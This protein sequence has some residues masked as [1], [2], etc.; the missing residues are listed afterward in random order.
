MYTIAKIKY[1]SKNKDYQKQHPN[2]VFPSKYFL[3]ETY[4]LDYKD[5]KE[6]GLATAKEI[7]DWT[8][9]YLSAPLKIL[10]WGCGV[11][12]IIRHIPALVPSNALV[13]GTDI[14][15]TMIDWNKQ[16]IKQVQFSAIGYNPPTHFDDVQFNLVYAL[17]VFTHIQVQQQKDWLAEMHRILS[18]NGIF[19][20]TT[21]GKNFES[22]LSK[23][24]K[25]ILHT[26]GALTIDYS[27][28]G[29]R[30]MSSYNEYE[31]F[32]NTIEKQFTIIAYYD[33]LQHPNIIGGQDMWIVRKEK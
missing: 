31:S 25:L 1:G 28:K 5:Y 18:V 30:M 12:R 6:D 10:E 3:Y 14:N 21:H 4:R 20:F 15:K 16:Y 27:Q 11:S 8:T 29:H 33:G 32:R 22:N 17:S 19:L 13:C 23:K 24:E 9:P 2:F 7:L 26:E